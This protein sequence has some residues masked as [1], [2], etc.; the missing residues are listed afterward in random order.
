MDSSIGKQQEQVEGRAF[1]VRRIFCY[2]ARHMNIAVLEVNCLPCYRS[3]CLRRVCRV[4]VD[5][6][7]RRGGIHV[8]CRVSVHMWQDV[9]YI[10]P[11]PFCITKSLPKNLRTA[12]EMAAYA[13]GSK[14]IDS[15]GRFTF[16]SEG[17]AKRLS[18]KLHR[19]H[20]KP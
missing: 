16:Y 9:A 4:W 11:F 5:R 8:K 19:A 17:S 1:P 10:M 15:A 2:Y 12:S 13:A 14:N 3:M 6:F 7:E 20:P 18:F